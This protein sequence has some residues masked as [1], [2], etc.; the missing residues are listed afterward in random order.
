MISVVIPLYNKEH[1]IDRTLLSVLNQTCKNFELII[2]D[3]GSKDGSVNRV[4]AYGDSRVRLIRKENGGPSSAR[5]LGVQQACGEWIVFLDAD[6][7]LLSYALEH[8]YTLIQQNPLIE[9]FCC[10]FYKEQN[11]NKDLYSHFYKKGIIKNNFY[12]WIRGR[13]MPRTGAAIFRKKVLLK[14]PFKEYLRRYEDAESLLNIMREYQIYRSPVPVMI[15][16]SDFLEASKK[17]PDI[18]QDYLGYLKL[19]NKSFWEKI[20]LYSLFRNAR[21][22]YPKEAKMLYKSLYCRIDLF[23]IYKLFD[24]TRKGECKMKK[25]ANKLFS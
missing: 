12:A 25:L 9:I 24:Y 17:R 21:R 22:T 18:K 7:E 11:G 1:C 3:D 4:K 20:I 13:C 15:Y 5:N 16:K 14:Y 23:L 19:E 10:N 8:F 6:D 2:V